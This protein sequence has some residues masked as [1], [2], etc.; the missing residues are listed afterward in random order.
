MSAKSSRQ[1]TKRV[2]SKA[3]KPKPNAQAIAP[4]TTVSKKKKSKAAK[5]K[6]PPAKAT[7]NEGSHAQPQQE[8]DTFYIV[9]EHDDLLIS[10][11][12]PSSNR[13]IETAGSFVEAKDKA[14]DYLIALIDSYERRL[15]KIKQADDVESLIEKR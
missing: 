2:T 6:K 5:A 8:S 4:P 10:T 12:K 14:V 3:A 1:T 7:N 15:W 11:D 9:V 13:R